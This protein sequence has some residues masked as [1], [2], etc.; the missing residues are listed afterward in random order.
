MNGL[1]GPLAFHTGDLLVV[2]PVFL[3]LVVGFVALAMWARHLVQIQADRAFH[4]SRDLDRSRE[5]SR[6]RLHFL[7]AISHDLR[8]PLNGMTLQT[9]VIEQA[10]QSHDEEAIAQAVQHIRAS[11]ATAA[12]IL[13]SLLQYARTEVQQNHPSR[14][15]LK[16]LLQQTADPFRAAAEEK[17]LLFSISVRD[18]IVLETDRD[19]LQRILANILDNAV[20][21]TARGTIT[22]RATLAPDGFPTA[23]ML[24]I[25]IVDTGEGLLP[26]HQENLF[27]EFFQA[28][29]PSRDSRLG[30]GLGLVLARRLTEQ[31]GGTLSCRS[32]RHKGSTFCIRL[33][34]SA[35]T[36]FDGKFDCSSQPPKAA[37]PTTLPS[38]P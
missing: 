2:I 34:L 25:E 23:R 36:T 4:L 21:F 10:L 37:S 8:T 38:P 20:K 5:E 17:L 24:A 19:K 30:L 18:D 13:D 14:I 35:H 29:N 11:S 7:N 32:E 12:E 33:P 16:E 6:R 9:H 3:L 31:L 27:N 15:W 22:L 1:D 26:E 28:N